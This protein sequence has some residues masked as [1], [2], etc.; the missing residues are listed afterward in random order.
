MLTGS[1]LLPGCAFERIN[2]VNRSA[3]AT[4]DATS[5]MIRQAS[6]NRPVVQFQN[7]QFVSPVPLP[8][9][10]YDAPREVVNCTLPY[11]TKKTG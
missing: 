11:L 8:A 6:E 2:D 9:A 10:K 3:E 5:S 1:L 7:S 4:A